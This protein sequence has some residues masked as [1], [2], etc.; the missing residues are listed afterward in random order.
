MKT[1]A[2]KEWGWGGGREE[3]KDKRKKR[4]GGGVVDGQAGKQAE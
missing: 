4:R 1:R 2:R 3:K